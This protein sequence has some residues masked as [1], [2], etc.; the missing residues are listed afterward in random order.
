MTFGPIGAAV[1]AGVGLIAGSMGHA[2]SVN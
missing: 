1:G 2:G